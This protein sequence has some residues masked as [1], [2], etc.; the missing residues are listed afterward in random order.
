[1]YAKLRDLCLCQSNQE[2]FPGWPFP[3]LFHGYEITREIFL[4]D[5]VLEYR[6]LD[7][8]RN[9]VRDGE[10]FRYRQL[11]DWFHY[12]FFNG[13]A[14]IVNSAEA[15]TLLPRL[16]CL[17]RHLLDALPTRTV[18]TYLEQELGI[19]ESD[20]VLGNILDAFRKV[21]EICRS[22]PILVWGMRANDEDL[23]LQVQYLETVSRIPAETVF[24]LPH[25]R[26]LKLSWDSELKAEEKEWGKAVARYNRWKK[27]SPRRYLTLAGQSGQCDD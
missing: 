13:I 9:Q 10:I 17:Q 15:C 22:H 2:D 8:G 19:A 16:L 27:L 5:P 12:R 21:T 6:V 23:P 26:R 18:H 7:L 25:I 24:E 11:N 3:M 4:L 14:Y 1:M 20:R